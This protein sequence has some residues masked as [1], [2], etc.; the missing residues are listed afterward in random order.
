[1][2]CS[3]VLSYEGARC[4]LINNEFIGGI[5]NMAVPT[6]SLRHLMKNREE[7]I[8]EREKD[9]LKRL[10]RV[11]F[12]SKEFPLEW[13]YGQ[14]SYTDGK[15]LYIKHDIQTP[16]HREFSKAEQATLRK[17]HGLHERGHCEYDYIPAY[18]EWKREHSTTLKS[19][20][21][22]NLRYPLSWLE[23][24]GN[25]SL[26]GRMER[27][28]M[29]DHPSTVPY[30]NFSNYAWRFGVRGEQA[31][32]S[33]LWDFRECFAS[34]V[35]GMTDVKE[36]D[37]E[38]V[39]LV[40]SVQ[41]KIK[42][43]RKEESTASCLNVVTSIIQEVWPTLLEWMD[44]VDESAEE[45][46][47]HIFIDSHEEGETEWGKQEEVEENV[48]RVL[49]RVISKSSIEKKEDVARGKQ[50]GPM[51]ENSLN[52]AGHEQDGLSGKDEE[53]VQGKDY[54]SA[55]Q[56]EEK[57]LSMD[58]KELDEQLGEY[59]KREEEIEIDPSKRLE[60]TR[61][62]EK[63]VVEP[64]KDD[65]LQRYKEAYQI[66]KRYINPTARTLQDL[67]APQADAVR[68]NQRRGKVMTNRIWRAE[69]L[70]E[71]TVFE[72]RAKGTPAIDARFLLNWDISGSTYEPY[73]NHRIV[74]EMRQ[75]AILLTEACERINLPA[76]VYGYT[77]YSYTTQHIFKPFGRFTDL[78]RATIGGVEPESGNR[79]TLSLQWAINQM[80]QH[81]EDI[82][83]IVM[84]S[85]GL[86]VFDR[87][88]DKDTMRD[89]VLQ[90][91]KK[92]IDVLCLFVGSPR[93]ASEVHYM[94]PGKAIVVSNNL[95]R[96][97]SR[98]VKRIIRKRR[99]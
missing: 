18:G 7:I 59:Q 1:M 51:E 23:F 38:A 72:R 10:I 56:Q 43:V 4:F 47:T 33:K 53:D 60:R 31:G 55:V 37:K 30:L 61:C 46:N 40:N 96:E 95:S 69:S 32:E 71:T 17:A 73:G 36:W 88:E 26:D 45:I 44:D 91:E 77:E 80:E 57:N 9:R 65:N 49:A 93:L 50:A 84:M 64:Y 6:H 78:E 52:T 22:S 25:M 5:M 24:F 63:V 68:K 29:L 19:E 92:D 62:S 97:L 20:W 85:D 54:L 34:R 99:G 81:D 15:T 27:L 14:T 86:P 16:H 3:V 70:G 11:M 94:Y 48:K 39:E 82:R 12:S 8:K 58:E 66:V 98:H 79:D 42:K 67:L 21:E 89:L 41:S 13:T 28:V 75:A 90:A 2:W 76:A 74:D 83:L 35:L 87:N